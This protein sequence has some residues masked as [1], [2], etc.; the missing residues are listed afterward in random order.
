MVK[1]ELPA[2]IYRCKGVIQVSEHPDR[3]AVLQC[4]GR[5]TDVTLDAAWGDH[6]AKT[7]IVAI[8]VPNELDADRL[9]FLFDGCIAGRERREDSESLPGMTTTR[10]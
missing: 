9:Q 10:I 7:Q 3:R 1:R 5:R 4:V 6:E 8:G 2:S